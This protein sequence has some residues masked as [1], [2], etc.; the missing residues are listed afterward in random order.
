M[1]SPLDLT[2][3]LRPAR[4]DVAGALRLGALLRE[5]RPGA[6]PP[7]AE[8]AAE[9]LAVAFGAL[10]RASRRGGAMDAAAVRRFDRQL[11]NLWAAVQDRLL[12]F[13]LL[14]EGD[15]QRVLAEAL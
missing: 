11:D 2:L 12:T 7:A 3:Y 1:L 6:L 8:R 14:A 13:T 15:P 9:R 5:A 4:L 10:E